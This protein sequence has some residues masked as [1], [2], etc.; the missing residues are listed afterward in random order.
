MAGQGVDGGVVRVEAQALHPPRHAH[1]PL[2][3]VR[4]P[5]PAPLG[6]PPVTGITDGKGLPNEMLGTQTLLNVPIT[7]TKHC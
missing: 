5:P 2:E 3:R 4:I 7:I 1:V 6:V